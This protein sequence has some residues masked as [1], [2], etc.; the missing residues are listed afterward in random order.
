VNVDER[1]PGFENRIRGLFEHQ[2]LDR[3]VL[4]YE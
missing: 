2:V 1:F 3:T 4:V